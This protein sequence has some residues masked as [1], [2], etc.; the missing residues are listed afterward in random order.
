MVDEAY[1]E[2]S[3]QASL[4]NEIDRFENLVILR[5][6]SKAYAL[7]GA[8]CG[9][10]LASASVIDLLSALM[11]PYAIS[12]PVTELVLSAL[13]K[14]NRAAVERQI[15]EIIHERNRLQ[16]RLGSLDA[17]ERV[18]PSLANFVLVRISQPE[19]ARGVL[20]NR[21][22]AI[23][24][25]DNIESLRNCSR[26]TVGAPDENDRLIETLITCEGRK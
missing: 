8:R 7:A 21:H 26:I 10:V 25:F 11:S 22:V 9:A 24:E 15:A 5:T 13:Q 3:G 19:N 20:A 4:A 18:W 2:F 16:K 6:L 14:E 12:T 1:V 17:I 23:R